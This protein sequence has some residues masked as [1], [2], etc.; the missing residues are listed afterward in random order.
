MVASDKNGRDY[1]ALAINEVALFRQSFQIARLRIGSHG[2]LDG[3]R[4]V[5]CRDAGGHPG[6]RVNRLAERGAELPRQRL[7]PKSR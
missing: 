7:R 5:G 4:A 3:Q 2:D 6:S 1:E